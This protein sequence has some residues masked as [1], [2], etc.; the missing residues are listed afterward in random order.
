M[1]NLPKNPTGWACKKCGKFDWYDS[2]K[3]LASPEHVPH[4]GAD[5]GTC[6]V[7]MI[8]LYDKEAINLANG[9]NHD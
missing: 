7:Q 2:A 1:I 3:N 9:D 8:A 6:G 5:I 4:R